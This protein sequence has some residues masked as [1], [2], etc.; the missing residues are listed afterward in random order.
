M[1]IKFLFILMVLA[2][3]FSTCITN[4]VPEVSQDEELLVV[5]AMITDAPGP[6]TVK[7]SKSTSIRQLSRFVTY[8][9]CHVSISDDLGNKVELIDKDKGVYQTDPTTFKTVAGR[10]YKISISTPD[11]EMYESAQEE[12]LKPVGIQNV[13]AEY[14]HRNDP[15]LFFGRDGYQFYLDTEAPPTTSNF[16][17]WQLQCT[18]KF[19]VDFEIDAYYADNKRTQVIN[20]DTLRTCYRTIDML[21]FFLLNANVL[22][23]SQVRRVPLN[24]EDNYTKALSMRYSLRVQQYTINE[25]AFTYWNTIKKIRDSQ[26]DLY[27][28][29]PFQVNNNLINLT[30]PEKKVLGYFTVAGI[31]E[32]RIFVNRPPYQAHFDVCKITGDGVKHLDDKL[33]LRPDLWPFFLVDPK[34]YNG[35]FWVDQ[36]CVD[37]RKTGVLEK[38][39]FW[40]D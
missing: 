20:G 32:K 38:P 35:D 31:A 36:S 21:D 40:V 37:C 30:H 22:K 15:K 28:Q 39:S 5:D 18:Y 4:F 27:S 8:P 2:I 29:Q 14:E 33:K 6:Y 3:F 25:A 19:Q 7:L 11:G 13:Y 1:K 23:Q 9:G 16:L 24:Y 26:G 10:S 34:E 17:L 12:L